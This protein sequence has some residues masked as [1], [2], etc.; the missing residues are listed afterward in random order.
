MKVVTMSPRKVVIAPPDRI[1][2]AREQTTALGRHWDGCRIGFDLG[3]SDRKVAAVQDGKV[4][5]I[6]GVTKE[7][8]AKVPAG[9]A[10][11]RYFEYC[12]SIAPRV[13]F[14]YHNNS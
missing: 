1:P 5:L 9:E 3:A 2:A 6:A 14:K 11:E 4:L 12:L 13:S 10:F 7:L 8:T